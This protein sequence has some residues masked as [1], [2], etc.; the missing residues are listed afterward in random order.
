MFKTKSVW[1]FWLTFLKNRSFQ[2]EMQS[3]KIRFPKESKKTG[4]KKKTFKFAVVHEAKDSGA[5]KVMFNFIY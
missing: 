1:L 2:E 4:K 3:M 5:K